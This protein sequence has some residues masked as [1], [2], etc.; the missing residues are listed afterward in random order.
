MMISTRNKEQW[1]RV[2]AWSKLPKYSDAFPSDPNDKQVE[3][4]YERY[5]KTCNTCDTYYRL[6]NK[7]VTLRA[8][9]KKICSACIRNAN[10]PWDN[11]IGNL[12]KVGNGKLDEIV[13]NWKPIVTS[14]LISCS[15]CEDETAG[16]KFSDTAGIICEKCF[17]TGKRCACGCGDPVIRAS[18]GI[19][20]RECWVT[21]GD[22]LGAV[23]A[24]RAEDMITRRS[25]A[26]WE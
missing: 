11:L 17:M 6:K 8:G 12:T 16:L 25:V 18:G 24:L 3:I 10:P 22:W 13:D 4:K 19:K 1:R 26:G 7:H 21:D 23:E 2:V 15:V 9:T 14:A 5:Q 20:C